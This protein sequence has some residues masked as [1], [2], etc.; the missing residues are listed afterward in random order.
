MESLTFRQLAE[1]EFGLFPGNP[2]LERPAGSPVIA[3]PSLVTKEESPD[4]RLH[5][6]AHTLWGIYH[7]LSDDGVRFEEA[8]RVVQRAMRPNIRRIGGTY[9]LFYEHLQTLCGRAAGALGGRWRS[10]IYCM[11]G[12][13]LRR[14]SKPYPVL[15]PDRECEAVG[16]SGCSLSN[17]FLLRTDGRFRLYYS[18]GLTK[19][20]QCGFSEPT[21]ICAAESGRPDGGYAK[22]GAPLI[23]P[24]PDSLYRS[25]CCGCIKVYKLKDAYAGLQ[26]GLYRE[27]GKDKSA[28]LLL[29]SDDGLSFDFVKP[30]ILPQTC[31]KSR[32]M[33]QFVYASHLIRYGDG[34]RL[35]FNARNTAS[36]LTGRE[37]IG[38]A[39]AKIPA[40]GECFR[41]NG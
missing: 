24:E 20:P 2:V 22:L 38:F 8:G 1:A 9:Y 3:D 33:A 28:V 14:W 12:A 15:G 30:L 4:G 41:H 5:L 39:E 17:P 31:G 18:C 25:L 29:R 7:Y 36:F 21:F 34:L 37:N 6:F 32:W 19:V 26:N 13:D 23:S 40:V 35:Y 10:C 27:D 16:K 11:T